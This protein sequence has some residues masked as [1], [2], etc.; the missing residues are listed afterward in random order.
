MS[1]KTCLLNC[2]FLSLL[3]FFIC[4]ISS[5]LVWPRMLIQ[6]TLLAWEQLSLPLPTRIPPGRCNRTVQ[7]IRIQVN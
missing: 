4:V 3:L 7:F 5:L 2:P 1:S 6:A